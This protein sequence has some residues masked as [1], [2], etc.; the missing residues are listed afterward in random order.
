MIRALVLRDSGKLE[1]AK[2]IFNEL[3]ESDVNNL[4]YKGNMARTLMKSKKFDEA[5]IL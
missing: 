4:E 3:I 5:E 2:I 1:E